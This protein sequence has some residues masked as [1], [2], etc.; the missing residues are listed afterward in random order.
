MISSAKPFDPAPLVPKIFLGATVAL[1]VSRP[2]IGDFD[3]A[4][5]TITC[6][7]GPLTHQLLTFLLLFAWGCWR[8][9]ARLPVT[10]GGGIVALL[11]IVLGCMIASTSINSTYAHASWCLVW[12]VA[13]LVAMVWIVR[14][15]RDAPGSSL[16]MLS[17]LIALAASISAQAVYQ[18]LARPLEWPDLEIPRIQPD[19]ILV[20][21]FA[22]TIP[23]AQLPPPTGTARGCFESSETLFLF[24]LPLLPIVL[25]LGHVS[26]W[27]QKTT[28]SRGRAIIVL[29]VGGAFLLAAW[30]FFETPRGPSWLKSHREASQIEYLIGE[31]PGTFSRHFYGELLTSGSSVGD[32]WVTLG[33]VTLA[34]LLLAVPLLVMRLSAARR[35]EESDIVQDSA[36]LRNVLL[37]GGMVGSLLGFVLSTGN[38]PAESPPNAVLNLGVVAGVRSFIFFAC[39]ALLQQ[40]SFSLRPMLQIVRIS[41]AL[42]FI[43]SLVSSR[44]SLMTVL[45]P[46]VVLMAIALNLRDNRG[47]QGEPPQAVW[48]PLL[49]CFGGMALLFTLVIQSFQP[50]L[51]TTTGV[52]EARQASRL[53]PE[54]MRDVDLGTGPRK[55][56][57]MQKMQSFLRANI[58]APLRN[59]CK[60]DPTNSILL[61]ETAHWLRLEWSYCLH[62]GDEKRAADVTREMLSLH[63]A[64][65]RLDPFNL[66]A[67]T[68]QLESLLYVFDSSKTLRKERA[69]LI[70][71]NL[72]Q[73]RER[74]PWEEFTAREKYLQILLR[75]HERPIAKPVEEERSFI[76]SLLEAEALTVFQLDAKYRES[77]KGFRGKEREEWMRKLQIAILE[78]TPELKSYLN[79]EPK[80]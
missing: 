54:L 70:E 41:I 59:A 69:V 79:P 65:V 19:A 29:L 10:F 63:E 74:F 53:L 15:W 28:R 73:I 78:P 14:Q 38:I 16:A 43:V 20:G 8:V 23:V 6:G 32:A 3:P 47:G 80:E 36:P 24:L 11:M 34:F 40:T 68:E 5:Q 50:G 45:H 52:R 67:L 35:G 27:H 1:L 26:W 48:K 4:R 66:V 42:V 44:L 46:F 55:L 60:S 58:L 64:A 61:I 57:A 77:N 12:E 75:V 25:F 21:D 30:S 31:G 76:R 37:A 22:A 72:S 33:V 56:Q 51:S 18:Q 2:L 7:A 49:I 39:L 71:K 62:L 17:V 9:K 13:S